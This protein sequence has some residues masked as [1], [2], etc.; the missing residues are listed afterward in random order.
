MRDILRSAGNFARR[1]RQRMQ[2]G[3][4]VAVAGRWLALCLLIAGVAAVGV[5]G[6]AGEPGGVNEALQ[7]ALSR[8]DVAGRTDE[9]LG[10]QEVD[11]KNAPVEMGDNGISNNLNNNLSN[12]SDNV[13]SADSGENS[14]LP[15][16]VD[17]PAMPNNSADGAGDKAEGEVEDMA[18]EPWVGDAVLQ[19]EAD[20]M[21]MVLPL[22]KESADVLR[23]FGYGYDETFAD[24]RFHGGVDWQA[25]EGETVLA[26]IA[27]RVDEITEDKVYGCGIRLGCGEK[28]QLVYYGL[29]PTE[30][31][32]KGDELA[33][34]EVVG[35]VAAAPLFED[36]YPA[37]LHLEVWLD[38]KV[39]DPSDYGL[40]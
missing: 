15:V 11:I 29:K 34:G 31:L 28:L 40:K 18:P 35:T 7:V 36:G 20:L 8:D 3:Q 21:T 19:A 24:Y 10:R 1:V 14:V 12:N 33:A 27:G 25:T 26:A 9:L 4:T 6:S 30:G 17:N 32:K 2:D 39:V 38:G 16:M 37:H 22:A 5:W 23:A 13:N